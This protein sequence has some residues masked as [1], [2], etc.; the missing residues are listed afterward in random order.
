MQPNEFKAKDASSTSQASDRFD[1]ISLTWSQNL[2]SSP[3][4]A[5]GNAQ[6]PHIE[7]LFWTSLTSPR[8]TYILVIK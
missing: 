4:D 1:T 3:K 6:E 5:N 8:H 7:K 2:Y